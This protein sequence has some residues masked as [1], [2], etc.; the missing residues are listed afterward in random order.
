MGEFFLNQMKKKVRMLCK[1][2]IETK[3]NDFQTPFNPN[4]I[5]YNTKPR[6][7]VFK[8]INFIIIV[9]ILI[10]NLLPATHSKK[11]E[12]EAT[13]DWASCGVVK[14]TPVRAFHKSTD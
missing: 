6:Y 12:R 10:L 13:K 9:N 11:V 8:L 3:C 5:E 2:K 14:K 4:I 1:I 7:L